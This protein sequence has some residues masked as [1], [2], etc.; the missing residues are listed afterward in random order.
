M[1]HVTVRELLERVG[2]VL[3]LS[4]AG[5][6]L[7]GTPDIT[8][9]SVSTPGLLLAGF[10]EGFRPDRIQVLDGT[11]LAYLASLGP[12]E[13]VAAFLRLCV[14]SVPCIIVV[15]GREIPRDLVEAASGRGIPILSSALAADAL[16][17]D[18]TAYLDDLLAPHTAIHGTLVDVYGVGLLFT[19]KSGIGKSECGL[20]LVEHGQRLVADDVVHVVRTRQDHVVGFGDESF[21]HYVE[22]RGVGIVDVQSMFG[23]RATRQRKRIEVEV[24]LVTWSDVVD[25]ERVGFEE[26]KTEILGVEIALVTLPLVPGK[27]ITVISEVIALNHLLK[28]HGI[29]TARELE[30]RLKDLTSEKQRVQKIIRGDNE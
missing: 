13:R 14:P 16:I 12:D 3:G 24:R 2:V 9:A 5:G 28:L 7:E 29:H 11:A 22:I 6:S 18:L 26:A 19:G 20:D 30:R 10:E 15:G 4:H 27:N 17:R 21:R 8:S 25:Y 23:I 1:E